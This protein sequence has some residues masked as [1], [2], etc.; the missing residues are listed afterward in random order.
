MRPF[1]VSKYGGCKEYPLCC[2]SHILK[3]DICCY[4]T[5]TFYYKD[6]MIIRSFRK[7]QGQGNLYSDEHHIYVFAIVGVEAG[8]LSHTIWMLMA[9]NIV[10]HLYKLLLQMSTLSET[11]LH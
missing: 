1:P 6:P 5:T 2:V 9:N 10:V 7:L 4:R 3:G 8:S 11:N